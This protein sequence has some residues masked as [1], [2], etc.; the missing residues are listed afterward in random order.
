MTL[1]P[2]TQGGAGDP[3]AAP[4]PDVTVPDVVEPFT[5]YRAWYI[6]NDGRL[7]SPTVGM[8]WEPGRREVATCKAN[9]TGV[10]GAFTAMTVQL[11]LLTGKVKKAAEC[12]ACPSPVKGPGAAVHPGHGCGI[13]AYRSIEVLAER[14]A[15][16]Y[17]LHHAVIGEVAVS[18]RVYE[19]EHG[20]RAQHATIT[21]LYAMPGQPAHQLEKIAAR[22]GVPVQPLPDEVH[23]PLLEQLDAEA[24]SEPDAECLWPSQRERIHR[25]RQRA[26]RRQTRRR[27]SA[28]VYAAL[29]GVQVPLVALAPTPFGL[30]I[31]WALATA[32]YVEHVAIPRWKENRHG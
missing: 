30:G 13:Y 25:Q 12:D 22:Y 29:L 3:G 1:D 20:Y 7:I 17:A 23:G 16:A 27:W 6:S 15:K 4:G 24:D 26:N 5:A 2:T 21:A 32:F 31:G 28:A 18:G 8:V 19:Y 14:A 9:G 10:F 11:D